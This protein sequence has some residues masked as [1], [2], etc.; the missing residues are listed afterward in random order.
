MSLVLNRVE[1]GIAWITLNRP[2]KHN[3]LSGALLAELDQTFAELKDTPE[4]RV[5]V[6]SGAGE[7]AFAA[8]ADIQGIQDRSPGEAEAAALRVQAILDRIQAFPRPVVAS[9]QGWALGGGLE[10][11]LACHI[12]IASSAARLGCPEV[13][14]GILPGYGATQRLPRLIGRAQAL[15]LLLTGNPVTGEEA[16]RMGL[17]GRVCAPQQL[18]E[19]TLN[20]AQTLARR[21]PLALAAVIQAVNEGSELPLSEGL[22]LEARLF[23]SL[24]RTLDR[25]EGL[26]AF[27]ERRLPDFRG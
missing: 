19:E 25:Q 18:E 7:K 23:G 14:L 24:E 15:Q 5:V 9:I 10:L 8:G 17:V 21:A 11:A 6:I 12:R 16:L 13:G 4:V 27:L 2:E 22:R 1:G 26:S 3:A 20:L